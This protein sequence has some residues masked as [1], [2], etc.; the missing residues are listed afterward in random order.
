MLL[1]SWYHEVEVYYHYEWY[2]IQSN[3]NSLFIIKVL[4][5]LSMYGLVKLVLSNFVKFVLLFQNQ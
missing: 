3:T 1:F 5:G 2:F 4:Y